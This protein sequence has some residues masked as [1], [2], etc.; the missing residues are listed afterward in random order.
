MKKQP[1]VSFYN[2]LVYQK[3]NRYLKPKENFK[4]LIQILKKKQDNR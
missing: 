4:F 1:K 2:N 3:K